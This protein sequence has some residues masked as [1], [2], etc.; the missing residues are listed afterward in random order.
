MTYLNRNRKLDYAAPEAVRQDIMD[1][2]RAEDAGAFQ[3]STPVRPGHGHEG[4]T[5]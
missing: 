1:D 4:G 2:I 5:L 3:W